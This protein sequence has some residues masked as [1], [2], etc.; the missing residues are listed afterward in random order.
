MKF[1]TVLHTLKSPQNVGTIIRTH[2]AF[3]GSEVVFVGQEKPWSF[4]KGT[5]AFSRKLERLCKMVFLP[6]DEALFGWCKEQ[7]YST[8]AVEIDHISTPVHSFQFPSAS[9]LIFGSEGHGL[10][11]EFLEGCDSVIRIPQP[12]A[13]GSLNVGVSAAIIMY[14]LSRASGVE[15]S[16]EGS[17]F[18]GE[19]KLCG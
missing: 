13:V 5:Q 14:E 18:A 10:T 1:C 8:V 19:P 11:R 7:G 12:G 2:V 16:I 4:G 17:K 6:T 15:Q 9:A 3:N